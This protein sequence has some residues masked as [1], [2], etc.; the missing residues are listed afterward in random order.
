MTAATTEFPTGRL[1]WATYVRRVEFVDTGLPPGRDY[2]PVTVPNRVRIEGH[3]VTHLLIRD[4]M[5]HVPYRL[6]IGEGGEPVVELRLSAAAIEETGNAD[7]DVFLVDRRPDEPVR[8]RLL[9]PAVGDGEPLFARDTERPGTDD[10]PTVW[11]RFFAA[12]IR[13]VA[14]G[15][16]NPGSA[17]P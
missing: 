17:R 13:Y 8:F 6:D 5:L 9:N 7:R 4:N 3:D 16:I 14:E 1:D 15:E 11:L 2:P 10:Y 12:D